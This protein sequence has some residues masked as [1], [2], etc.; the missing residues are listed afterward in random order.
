MPNWTQVLREI[1][2]EA[3]APDINPLDRVRRKYLKKLSEHT[4]RNVIA[5]YSGWLQKPEFLIASMNDNDMNNFMAT[6]HG[7][8]RS[9]GLDLILHTPGGGVAALEAIVNY[10]RSM[11]GR[12][13]RAFIPQLAMSAG[14]MLACSCKEIYM[15]K[16]S[17]IGPIDPQFNGIS[18]EGVI[19]EFNEAIKKV[20][21]DPESLEIWALIISKYHPTFIGDCE[22]AVIWAKRMLTDWLESGMF[23]KD[24]KS[25]SKIKKIVKKLSSHKSNFSHSRHINTEQCKEI[26]LKIKELEKDKTLQDLVLTVHHAYMHTF[27]SSDA[28]KIVENHRGQA[29]ITNKPKK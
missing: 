19:D 7:L 22:K 13:I 6:I 20:K 28:C 15:G 25:K 4:K 11:F 18:A 8:D 5:Y 3:I 2:A 17:N 1:Q 9:K 29:I 24:K 12:D 26:D 21:K 23:Y 10:L 14:T 16:H 27:S